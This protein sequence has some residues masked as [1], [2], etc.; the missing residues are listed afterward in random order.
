[1][2][3]K[4]IITLSLAMLICCLGAACATTVY[5]ADVCVYGGTASGVTAGLAAAR[6]GQSVIIVEPFRHLGG[7]HG[8]GIRIQQDCLYLKDIGGIARELHDADYALPGGGGA[9]QWQARLMIR[10]KV[11]DAG[12]RFFTQY[13]LDSK[14][15]VVKDG[16]TI[17][18]IHLN[19]APIMEEG[20][21]PAEPQRRKALSIKAKVFIDASY[22]GDLMAF[23][24]CDYTIGREAKSEYNESLG[25]QRGLKY[26]DVDPYVAEGDPSSGLLPMISTE[27]Y[28]PDAA[29]RYSLAY[30]FRMQGMRDRKSGQTEGTPLKPLARKIDRERYEL[31]IRGLKK[32][33]GK[34]VIG[35]P[36]WNYLRKTMVSSGP[37]GRQ[38]DYPDGDWDLRSAVW[39]DWIDHVKTMNILRGIK[40]PVLREGWYPDNGD[41]PD[42]L[43]IRIGRRMIGEYVMTQHDLM[44]QT[45]IQDSIGLAYY[46]V[47]IYPPR[48]I[49]HEGKVASEGEVF[50]RVSPGPYQIPY[51]ALTAKKDQCDNLLV[52]V[53][54]SASHIAMSSIRMESSYVVMGEAAGIAASHAVKSDKNVHQL[55]VE[56]VLAD[57]SKAGVVTEWDGTGYGPNS[58]R[59]WRPDAIYWKHNPEDYKKIPIRLDPSWQN[60]ES[61]GGG[62]GRTRVQAFSSVEDWN[63]KKPG[64]DWLFPHIDKNA[65]GK[66]SLEEH[67]AFQDYKKA[68]PAWQ[69]TLRK[70]PPR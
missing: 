53:C 14:E 8:G 61:T 43:Y 27:P 32:D 20:V 24:G 4:R 12:I 69:K 28:E 13:R 42:Q 54:M 45:A 38:A 26:F 44:H 48:L 60:S 66:I 58:R 68:N 16:A 17:G 31:V 55:D 56:A 29:S 10:K 1:M 52:S 40:A 9:N 51:R 41:F 63:Q 25:G 18:M 33:S 3:V 15:D 50:M 49:A 70:K 30:N 67:Q 2:S 59:T 36:A 23:S 47:D 19:H 22:E 7:M 62:S 34:D 64:Y 57:M 11:E 46:A 65:D 37:P 6:R 39:R 5:E 35:W 21:P